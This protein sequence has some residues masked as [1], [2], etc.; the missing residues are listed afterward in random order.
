MQPAPDKS[1]DAA[2]DRPVETCLAV[3]LDHLE[4]PSAHFA[5]RG[6]ADLQGFMSRHPERLASLTLLCP[7]V[8]DPR[9]L[10]PLAGRLLVVTGDRG[11]GAR[12]VEAGLSELRQAT[13]VVLADYTGHTW[14]D[15]AAERGDGIGTAIQEFLAS[16]ALPR[17]PPAAGLGEQEGEI[18]GISYRVRGAG[19]PLIL[20]PL[21][22]S[23]GQWEP[24]IPALSARYCTITLGGALFG[25][26]A[27]LEERGRSG[28]MAVVRAL[29]DALAIVP[30][31]SVLEVG[32]GSGVIMRELARRTAVG[33][34]PT[35]LSRGANRLI[36]R[37]MSPY[38]LRE[39]RALARRAGLLDRIDFGEG[40]AESLPLADGA[41]DVA[42]SSTVFEEGDADLMLSEIVR[43]TRPGGRVG[44]V[45][46]AID[47]PFWVN[48]PL[49]PA[50]KAKVDAP[51]IIGGGAAPEG[52]ADASL[53]RRLAAL[54]LTGLKCFPQMVAVVPGSER[55]ERYQQQIFAALTPAETKAF[56]EA[57][58]VAE[59][60][61]T[62]FIAQSYHCAVGTKPG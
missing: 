20:L 17:V 43:V 41:V 14:A 54:G 22:L 9:T 36:G 58:A 23:P 51:G 19:P 7:A 29:L 10:A 37:D 61:G 1:S 53:Y 47:M 40:R 27:S 2:E 55:I 38:L 6:S 8:L 33:P 48:L 12:R 26:V 15:I 35:G 57:V 5:A 4:V 46:R 44:I 45:V 28:Y 60:D 13:A 50:L 25:S 24:L 59:R 18:A 16:P 32:C 39:A 42:L 11:P 3:L 56:R 49:D 62:F 52:V 34:P 31:E 21:D 30:G